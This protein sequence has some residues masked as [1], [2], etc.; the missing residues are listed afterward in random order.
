MS[1]CLEKIATQYMSH[2]IQWEV[3]KACTAHLHHFS[4]FYGLAPPLL[5]NTYT[6]LYIYII[7]IIV[8]VSYLGSMPYFFSRTLGL[9]CVPSEELKGEFQVLKPRAHLGG[10]WYVNLPTWSSPVS[11]Y[12]TIVCPTIC[13][14][15]TDLGTVWLQV[16]GHQGGN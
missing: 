4:T 16:E 15:I 10:Q 9:R 13:Q 5:H 7:V 1:K 2:L 8:M 6:L 14:A 11:H 12:P 3:E